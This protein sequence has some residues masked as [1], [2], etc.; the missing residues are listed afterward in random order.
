MPKIIQTKELENCFSAR[1]MPLDR[2]E[3]R[4][5]R[6]GATYMMEGSIQ[7][8]EGEVAGCWQIVRYETLSASVL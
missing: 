3:D 4:T 8:D 6:Q 1:N 5:G 7:M 2:V